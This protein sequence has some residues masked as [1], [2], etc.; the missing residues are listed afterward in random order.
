MGENHNLNT[1]FY[2]LSIYEKKS[3]LRI[4]GEEKLLKLS[5]KFSIFGGRKT[6]KI[7]VHKGFH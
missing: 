1:A 2:V 4:P 6:A 5:K 7:K 3:I